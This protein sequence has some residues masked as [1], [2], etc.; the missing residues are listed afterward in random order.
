MLMVLF[1]VYSLLKAMVE[2][3]FVD[4]TDH[5]AKALKEIEGYLDAALETYKK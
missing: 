4:R 5:S 1:C 2:R 3:E